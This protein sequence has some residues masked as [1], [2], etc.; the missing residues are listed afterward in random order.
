MMPVPASSGAGRKLRRAAMI[1][2]ATARRTP[3]LVIEKIRCEDKF[4]LFDEGLFKRD[5]S[6]K[7]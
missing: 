3:L 6:E 2:S 1:R 4:L 5:R 7:L